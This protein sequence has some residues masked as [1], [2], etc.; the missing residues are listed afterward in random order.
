M[1]SNSRL[2]ASSNEEHDARI[3]ELR[4]A[5]TKHDAR[6]AELQERL[7]VFRAEEVEAIRQVDE[8]FAK[9]KALTEEREE[10][11][12]QLLLSGHAVDVR[13][14]PACATVAAARRQSIDNPTAAPAA[15]RTKPLSAKEKRARASMG[16]GTADSAAPPPS[17]QQRRVS[18]PASQD[19]PSSRASLEGAKPR[20]KPTAKELSA[21]SSTSSASSPPTRQSSER[22]EP[23]A[24]REGIVEPTDEEASKAVADET[25]LTSPSHM[26]AHFRTLALEKH[27]AERDDAPLLGTKNS[28]RLRMLINRSPAAK[29]GFRAFLMWVES[30]DRKQR[31]SVELKYLAY[32]PGGE[33]LA[34]ELLDAMVQRLETSRGGEISTKI[35]DRMTKQL[36]EYAHAA[37]ARLAALSPTDVNAAVVRTVAS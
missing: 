10:I 22:S 17:K 26:T 37:H 16:S 9:R 34:L 25:V 15:A 11:Q 13:A 27:L 2:S 30:W 4:S 20:P 18:A 36:L 7:A 35:H 3:N 21:A 1:E 6:I 12:R 8:A 19:L 32:E 24:V 14:C 33:A 29:L 31:H 28:N 23:S 5:I